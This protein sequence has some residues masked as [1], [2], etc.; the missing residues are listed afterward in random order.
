MASRFPG[1]IRDFTFIEKAYVCRLRTMRLKLNPRFFGGRTVTTIGGPVDV[2]ALLKAIFDQYDDDQEHLVL[3]IL[4]PAHEVV[5]FKLIASGS[6]DKVHVDPKVLVRSALLLGAH[7][8]MLAH[9]HPGGQRE[10][11]K[12]DVDVTTELVDLTKR[13]DID[14]V[15]HWI[16]L[17]SGT[18]V[19]MKERY[20]NLFPA[21]P[22]TEE[23]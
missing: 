23:L 11:S 1:Q 12:H 16:Y 19:S 6:Q 22:L 21:D 9:N 20:P 10:P 13:L 8:I 5:G 18:C 17:P 3:L 2:Q 4:N 15:E 14:L 7:S